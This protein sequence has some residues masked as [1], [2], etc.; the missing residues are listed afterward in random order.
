MAALVLGRPNRSSK[1]SPALEAENFDEFGVSF[2]PGE[3]QSLNPEAPLELTAI[4]LVREPLDAGAATF[5]NAARRAATC[6]LMLREALRSVAGASSSTGGGRVAG[7]VLMVEGV[8]RREG[9]TV[10]RGGVMG[11]WEVLSTSGFKEGV[12]F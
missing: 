1:E 11:V 5:F 2:G 9:A 3:S 4:L 10:F 7:L 8:G 12:D 6:S